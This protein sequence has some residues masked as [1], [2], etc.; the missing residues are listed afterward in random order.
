MKKTSTTTT[1]SDTPHVRMSMDRGIKQQS[2]PP[3]PVKVNMGI[4][5]AAAAATLWSSNESAAKW[6]EVKI[7]GKNICRRSYHTSVFYQDS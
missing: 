3:Q 2:V 7:N 5:A 1:V 4:T 6:S